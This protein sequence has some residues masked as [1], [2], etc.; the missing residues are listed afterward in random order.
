MRSADKVLIGIVIGIV[1]LVLVV[2]AVTLL[3]PEAEYRSDDD[4][5]GVV[6]NYLLAL[7]NEDFDRA[8]QYLWMG[9]TGFPA[10]AQ[11]FEDNVEDHRW[12][13]H[14]NTNNTLSVG[15]AEIS[16]DTATVSVRETRF[17]EN[18]LFDSDQRVG[19]FDMELRK[20]G[21][22]WRIYDGDAYFVRCWAYEDGCR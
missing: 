13:F 21:G 8:Y 9:L 14:A 5:A 12:S 10:N 2:F 11:R 7:Q 19:E 4:P 6:H 3:R 16:G 15:E 1:V 18:G 22:G 20:E 17:Y